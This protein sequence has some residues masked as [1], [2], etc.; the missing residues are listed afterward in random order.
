MS[1]IY[2]YLLNNL[3][4]YTSVM[5]VK[6]FSELKKPIFFFSVIFTFTLIS[7]GVFVYS[8][9][10]GYAELVL[11]AGLPGDSMGEM[12]ARPILYLWLYLKQPN[13]F[14]NM[15]MGF[16]AI[17]WVHF[18]I[19]FFFFY[20]RKEDLLD[21][22][23]NVWLSHY[24]HKFRGRILLLFFFNKFTWFNN[25]KLLNQ[26]LWKIWLLKTVLYFL[27]FLVNL[28]FIKDFVPH[29]FCMG[30]LVMFVYQF[31]RL[32]CVLLILLFYTVGCHYDIFDDNYK[33]NYLQ[34]LRV[35]L[36]WNTA[37]LSIIIVLFT[38]SLL[39]YYDYL[40]SSLTFTRFLPTVIFLLLGLFYNVTLF[41]ACWRCSGFLIVKFFIL[42]GFDLN[43]H[44]DVHAK[45]LENNYD[46]ISLCLVILYII[47]YIEKELLS[48]LQKCYVNCDIFFIYV[49]IVRGLSGVI[50]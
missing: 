43:A 28:I 14:W 8:S 4:K 40:F 49:K 25:L 46:F 37:F 26:D 31:M 21:D 23:H 15:F 6:S 17:R 3:K 5:F 42:F 44:L 32:C 34:F 36:S 39:F 30:I 33:N 45:F 11:F 12:Y 19:M 38:F 13:H 35:Y 1:I 27:P 9:V 7:V 2:N 18:C 50:G 41:Y 48:T 47:F 22:A 10:H 16:Y 24:V 20:Y 29:V